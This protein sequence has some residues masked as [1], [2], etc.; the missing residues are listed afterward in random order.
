LQP[1][2]ADDPATAFDET[3]YASPMVA[4]L[5]N[6]AHGVTLQDCTVDG[7][8][9]GIHARNS[10]HP[11]GPAANQLG[12]TILSNTFQIRY[13][14]ICLLDVDDMQISDND[15]TATSSVA[16]SISVWRDSDRNLVQRSW[17]VNHAEGVT[18]GPMQYVP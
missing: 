9:V 6:G 10:K 14:G 7:F 12:N 16:T 11:A 15:I 8:D 3:V 2:V 17:L 5:F 1:G 18:F 4:F 13:S